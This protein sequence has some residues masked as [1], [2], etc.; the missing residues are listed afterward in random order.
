MITWLIEPGSSRLLTLLVELR[1]SSGPPGEP[2]LVTE[3]NIWGC[4]PWNPPKPRW[5]SPVARSYPVSSHISVNHPFT[6]VCSTAPLMFGGHVEARGN[7]FCTPPVVLI[8]FK[9][10]GNTAGYLWI[11]FGLVWFVLRWEVG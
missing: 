8:S 7:V 10:R 1:N 6:H 11:G 3:S 9:L 2:S 4:P 5:S